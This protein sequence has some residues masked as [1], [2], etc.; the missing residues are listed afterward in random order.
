MQKALTSG[1][2]EMLRDI[3][4][5]MDAFEEARDLTQEQTERKET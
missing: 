5:L 3:K 4:T 1:D 2:G